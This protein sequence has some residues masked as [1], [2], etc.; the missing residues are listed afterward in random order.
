LVWS[1]SNDAPDTRKRNGQEV[2]SDYPAAASPRRR[3]S[4]RP[5]N[6]DG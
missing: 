4:R 5:A 1:R 2:E 6:E 3:R